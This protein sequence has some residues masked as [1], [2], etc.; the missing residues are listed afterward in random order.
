[1]A[2]LGQR[3]RSSTSEDS[4]CMGTT[5]DH[6]RRMN[7]WTD[8]CCILQVNAWREQDGENVTKNSNVL[9]DLARQLLND[10]RTN[11]RDPEE[12]PAS[13]LLLERDAAGEPLEEIHLV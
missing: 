12:D 3:H 6:T 9:Y 8:K 7:N 2:E 1:M 13:S 4:S 5:I 11:P 10:R